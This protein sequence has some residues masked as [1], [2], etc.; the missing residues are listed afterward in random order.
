MDKFWHYW[1]CVVVA[2]LAAVIV[3]EPEPISDS[4]YDDDYGEI[5]LISLYNVILT[6]TLNDFMFQTPTDLTVGTAGAWSTVA[7]AVAST[8]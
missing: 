6:Y 3:A 2:N 1:Y 8:R 7:G 5:M 4:Y